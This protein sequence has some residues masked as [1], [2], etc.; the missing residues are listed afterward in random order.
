M[1][2]EVVSFLASSQLQTSLANSEYDQILGRDLFQ[3]FFEKLV[4]RIDCFCQLGTIILAVF[5][6]TELEQ[7]V[8]LQFRKRYLFMK[9]KRGSKNLAE[10]RCLLRFFIES[11]MIKRILDIQIVADDIT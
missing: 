11:G 2:T 5:V 9:R 1:Q 7:L 6:A 3:T 10:C 8:C 4:C